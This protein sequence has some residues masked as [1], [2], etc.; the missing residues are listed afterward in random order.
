[1]RRVVA[2]LTSISLLLTSLAV[3]TSSARAATVLPPGFVSEAVVTNLTGPTTVAFAP[4]G[5]LFIG[6]KDGRVRVFQNGVLLPTDFINIS[7]QVNNN[8]D[9]GLLG[10]AIHPDF[11]NT[12]YIYLL[13]TYDP[14]GVTADGGGARVSRLLRVTANPANTNVALAG[15]EV[16]LLGTNST[17]ANIGNPANN[18]LPFES[19]K[20][21][22]T[23][24]Q[25]CIA[26]DSPSHTI[27]TVTFGTDGSLFVSSGDGAH[28]S[29]VD[30]RALRALS[31]DSLNGKILRINPITGEGY[32]DNPFYDGDPN[33]NRSKVY[34]LGLRNP[35][36]TTINDITGEPFAGDVG[37]GSWEEINTGRGKNFGWPC[38]EGSDTGSTQ[39]GGYRN[40]SSTSATCA[41]LYAQGLGAVQAPVH[42][43][44]H[45]QGASAIQAG[46][47]YR[48]SSY[49]AQ[50]KDALFFSDYNADWI[51]YLT[52]DANGVATKFD[53][54][55]DVAP[56]GGIVQLLIGPDTN[57][58]YVAYNGPSPNTSE[59]R[60]IRYV[61]GGNT[62]PTANASADPDAGTVPLVVNFSSA[63]SFDPDAQPLTYAW[64]F[65]DS[66][67][68]TG[69]SPSYTYTTS[70]VFTV[71]LTV[72]DS[73]GA[74][75]TDTVEITVGNSQ[76]VATI[77]TPV[78]GFAY[79]TDDTINYSG[80]GVDPE[81]GN[82]S[83]A[84][85]QW[86]ILLHHNQHIH[87]DF[88]PGL[89]GT[90]GNFPVPDHGDNTWIELCLTVT[91]SGG[92]NDQ[93]CVN[94]QPNVVTLSFDT[95]PSGLELEYDGVTYTT[96][97]N[98]TTNVNSVRDLIA[99]L[100][101]EG[102]HNFTSWSDGGA[103][104]HQITTT[105]TPQTFIAT[106]TPCP[107]T[108]TVNSGQSKIYGSTNP[109]YVYT[110]SNAAVTF[111]GVLNRLAGENVGTY[112]ID[113]GTLAVAD[114]TQYTMTSFVAA[115]FTINP[116]VASVSSNAASKI[117]SSVDPALTGTLNGFLPAD[118]VT[119][120]YSR[121]SG[122]T[123]AGSPYTISAVLNPV[124]ML[125][126]YNITYN[127]ANFTI[128]PKAASVSPNAAGK[129]F[130]SVDP[131]LTGTLNGFLPADNVTA[132]YTRT[133][134]ETVAGSPYTI[135]ATL[136]PL[137]IL[138]NYTVTSNAANFTITQASS[139]VSLSNLNYIY[140]GTPKS[141]TATTNPPGLP[142]DINYNGSSTPPTDAGSYTVVA[143]VNHPN[144]TG[145]ASNTFIIAKATVTP[146]ITADNKIY[147]GTT[148]AVIVNRNL[149][150]VFFGDTVNL[151]G[152]TATFANKN[153]GNNKMVTATSLTLSGADA[154]NYQLSSTSATTTANVTP[155]TLT[156]TATGVNKGYDG[157]ATAT[158]TLSDDRVG[159]DNLNTNY[160]A[161]SFSDPSVGTAKTVSVSGITISGGDA[162]NYTLGNTTAATIAD[163]T[164]ANQTITVT[165]SAPATASN[166]ST[167]SVAATASS[168]LPVAI[169]TS[170]ICTGSGINTAA[171][172]MNSG[173]GSCNIFYDQIG[174]VNYNPAIQ[175]EENVGATEKP[176]ITSNDNVTFS[177][178]FP[179]T[180]TITTA[181]NPSTPMDITI[182]GTI[183]AGVTFTDNND[184]TAVLSG[185][186]TVAGTFNLT[187]RANNGV[188]P[189]ASQSFIL[190]V[191]NGPIIGARGIN[192]VPDT[193]NGSISENEGVLDTLGISQL[194]VEFSQDV[195]NL[196]GNDPNY[197]DSVTNP[198]NYLLVLGSSTGQFQTSSCSA[199]IVEPDIAISVDNVTYDNN[200]GAG[201][202][203]AT[204]NING[205]LPLN[206]V[207]FYR[208]YVCGTTSIVDALNPNLILAG[209]GSTPGTDFIRNFRVSTRVA[210]VGNGNTNN[211]NNSSPSI[212]SLLIPV[213]G[214]AP[215]E[216]TPLPAQPKDKA[217]KA[218]GD[219]RIEIPTLG[220][221][222]PIVGA[223]VNKN[224]WDLTW[225]KDNVAYLEG[226][227]YPTLAGN[228]VLTAHVIDSN[229]NPGPFSDVKGMQEG[230][231][232]YIHTN[233]QTYVYQV[234]EN[235]KIMPTNI[236]A[237]FKHEEYSWI[238]LVTCEDYN[239]KTGLYKYR[240]MVRAVL[241]S[242]I[243][244]KQLESTSKKLGEAA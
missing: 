120:V 80:T 69:P 211:N 203:I 171:I 170:G 89:I 173:S 154:L 140:D 139:T 77:I 196:P 124:N 14:P 127:S 216:I 78:D 202:F 1:M 115:N 39:Q 132:V 100:T 17:F 57:L 60:R 79:S 218:L 230:Q 138:G 47:F 220:I 241:I 228:T 219:I 122:E 180:F 181:G 184:G 33:S 153:V 76:P 174:N 66:N 8:W 201:P 64:N 234:Q 209:N 121:A 204:L 32:P 52:F 210:A 42:A 152:G 165:T 240:R 156:I 83:G 41:A 225:L 85:L 160:T 55:T 3:P 198:A 18:N 185:T 144:Y 44:N 227:A 214:F 20:S 205:G 200:E 19:C 10:I 88:I 175:I 233:G 54:G 15:S 123:V 22:A 242:V 96:P 143:T 48:G 130:G 213:T 168:G 61:S 16:V 119:A 147:D 128:T 73:L 43:Y 158:V 37:W 82:L 224:G 188:L 126:N 134:G 162:G 187:F 40:S 50:Y 21:G 192:S 131:A 46:G 81:D 5:R 99:P 191:K 221:S 103:A 24:I 215:G 166:G 49:P 223:A 231:K 118:N 237:V 232:I 239:A 197:G 68:G 135:S 56:V 35:F 148:A 136:N 108:V 116:K 151:S 161:A 150:G 199:G 244:A 178:G 28:F 71:T 163:I 101:Q 13:Y 92:L 84:S 93:D 193:G 97:F 169:T 94:L 145:V 67:T 25:D 45:S 38:Y 206:V 172:T 87:F 23:Y 190:T 106:Y 102:C 117:Y 164:T 133:P 58:Y 74:T 51:R 226:S 157:T 109:V 86:D 107:V 29:Y 91:D 110:A 27:G 70:G 53:F 194:T 34:S 111:T 137:A 36:R 208:L 186:P 195:L 7:A 182:A 113:Q 95:I 9:R 236:S 6:Q 112:A 65:G 75:G 167:F 59:V 149:T 235:R 177:L 183:P 4:D 141:V 146:A 222:Y 72:T 12:P 155:R 176:S 30:V 159:G 243:S 129:N 207:G 98:I 217:Y 90:S 229:N 179:D 26:A 212:S 63:G 11:P 104:T 189:N 125:G 105:S 238:T 114:S 31:V 62:P 142:V 2:V